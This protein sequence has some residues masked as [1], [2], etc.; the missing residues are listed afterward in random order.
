MQPTQSKS[1]V[2]SN[3]EPKFSIGLGITSDPSWEIAVKGG[4]LGKSE[5]QAQMLVVFWGTVTGI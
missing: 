2:I 3:I 4:I 1:V 5:D